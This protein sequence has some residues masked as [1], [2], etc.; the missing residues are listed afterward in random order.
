MKKIKVFYA[1]I[2]NMGDLLNE[3]I[4]ENIFGY[5]VIQSGRLDC[6]TS[7]I[8]SSLSSFFPPK[9][10]MPPKPKYF[11]QKL[12]GQILPIQ[13]WST[14]F[15]SYSNDEHYCVRKVNNVASVRGE[16][17]KKRLEGILGKKLDVPTGDGGLLASSLID[18]KNEK[19]FSI[20]IIPHFKE[21]HEP[22]FK[23]LQANYNNSVIIDLTDEP[24]N[25][26]KAISQCEVI[27]SSSL[28]GLVVADSFGIP[29]MR[30]VY[31]D[32]LLGDGF[33]FDDYYSSYNVESTYFDL[34]RSGYPK[35][36]DVIDGYKIEKAVVETKKKEIMESFSKYL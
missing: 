15:I 18:N 36:N 32:K 1:K 29:N 23:E 7:G 24:M 20:G 2:N 35:I 30:L 8:G 28:H 27:I 22:R 5:K 31:S 33:K 9:T 10:K 19:K 14:G 17:S 21:K 16:L 6:H 12:Y 11:I 4:I 3:L 25:V 13:I 26:I 34:K